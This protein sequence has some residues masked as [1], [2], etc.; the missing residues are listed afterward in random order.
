M[1][2]HIAGRKAIVCASSRGLG[3]ACALSLSREGVTVYVN[4]RHEDGV[5]ETAEAIHRATGHPVFGAALAA[6]CPDADILVNNNAGPP[7]GKF[8]DWGRDDYLQAIEANMLAPVLMIR[9]L[10]PGMRARRFG[11][12]VNITSAM[13]KAPRAHQG[14]STSARTALTALCKAISTETV[15]DNVTINNLL[16]ER[17]DTGRQQ[18]MIERQSKLD[19]IPL[20]DARRKLENT[21]AARRFGRTEEFGDMCAYLCSSQASFICGQNVQVD[22]GSY[23]GL[24]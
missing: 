23:P 4:S 7:P 21:I 19:N 24:V 10:L 2:L 16:P 1:D 14:L 17:I 22:G 5:R 12:I 8:Q 11:R 20:A 18:F 6:A 13:V 15:A 3:K 9:A